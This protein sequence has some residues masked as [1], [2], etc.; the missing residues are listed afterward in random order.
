M[1]FQAVRVTVRI[2]II[3]FNLDFVVSP[4]ILWIICGFQLLVDS[5]WLPEDP[6]GIHTGFELGSHWFLVGFGWIRGW[7]IGWILCGM[8]SSVLGWILNEIPGAR[9]ILVVIAFDWED[10][11]NWIQFGFLLIRLGLSDY[12]WLP[13]SF[14][15]RVII[16]G[17]LL[18]SHWLDSRLDSRLGFSFRSWLD[19]KI[20]IWKRMAALT[21]PK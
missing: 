8:F 13:A 14:G 16:G 21:V 17:F 9:W 19:S 2:P 15:F 5:L 4:W 10:S 6:R 11:N 3:G 18:D 7:I 20:L 12:R 1:R